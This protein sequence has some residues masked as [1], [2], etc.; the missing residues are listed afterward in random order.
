MCSMSA[1]AQKLRPAPVIT[2]ARTLSFDSSFFNVAVNSLHHFRV[3]GVVHFGPVEHH[4]G[5][6]VGV[7]LRQDFVA[8]RVSGKYLG[9]KAHI[10]AATPGENVD[11]GS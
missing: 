1:P 8:H 6:A 3:E 5:I 4:G 11:R 9:G 2:T 7:D 10:I